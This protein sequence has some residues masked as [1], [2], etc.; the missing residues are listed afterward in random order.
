M[1]PSLAG[2]TLR[3]D[4]RIKETVRKLLPGESTTTK[5]TDAI[6]FRPLDALKIVDRVRDVNKE[7]NSGWLA[8]IVAIHFN[9]PTIVQKLLERGA[10]VE[11]INKMF[12]RNTALIDAVNFYNGDVAIVK[13]LLD[14]GADPNNTNKFGDAAL[15][16]AS[17]QGMFDV[18]TLLLERGANV[19]VIDGN[20]VTTNEEI[21]DLIDSAW[22][23]R[24]GYI[25]RKVFRDD[26]AKRVA[27]RFHLKLLVM[28][29]DKNFAPPMN[30]NEGGRRFYDVKRE[31]ED[32]AR[33]YNKY[34]KQRIAGDASMSFSDFLR[35]RMRGTI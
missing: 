33:E 19:N 17:A 15:D 9:R 35:A 24:G 14:Y 8:L 32:A 27:A 2:L 5:L 29:N 16:Y 11:S 22:Y 25:L 23:I 31:Y 20:N 34:K 3:T 6:R 13:T 26:I 28:V 4:A 18:V 10:N 1:L 30:G 7:D 21:W 12:S